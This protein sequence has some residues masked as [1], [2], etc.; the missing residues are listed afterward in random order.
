MPVLGPLPSARI[1]RHN[2]LSAQRF[3]AAFASAGQCPDRAGACS[4]ASPVAALRLQTTMCPPA[5]PGTNGRAAEPR[6]TASV[7]NAYLDRFQQTF[8]FRTAVAIPPRMAQKDCDGAGCCLSFGH[9]RPARTGSAGAPFHPETGHAG[10][11]SGTTVATTILLGSHPS[12]P[13][14]RQRQPRPGHE[15]NG[16]L[17]LAGAGGSPIRS[18]AGP[19]SAS[20]PRPPGREPG[21]GR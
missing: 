11:S 10:S 19:G 3:R 14:L 15:R 9:G 5:R 2:S 17:A 6:D 21:T 16:F 7:P 8:L 13:P 18:V 20:P 1:R 4:V 12:R